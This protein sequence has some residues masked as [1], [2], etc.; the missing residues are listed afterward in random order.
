MEQKYNIVAHTSLWN[1]KIYTKGRL[2]KKQVQNF[3]HCPKFL[4]PPTPPQKFGHP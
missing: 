1:A 3:G 4:V 2:P